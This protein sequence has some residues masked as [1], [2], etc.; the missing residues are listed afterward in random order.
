MVVLCI[1]LV[2]L[3]VCPLP[4]PAVQGGGGRHG[5]PSVSAAQNQEAEP[6]LLSGPGLRQPSQDG[7]HP[8]VSKSK[9]DGSQAVQSSGVQPL[10]KLMCLPRIN[11]FM[12]TIKN[13]MFL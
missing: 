10:W 11:I 9:H 4:S 3:C 2:I 6:A 12:S 1:E 8:L 13:K 7:R 5:D